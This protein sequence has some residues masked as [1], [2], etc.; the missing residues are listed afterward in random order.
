MVKTPDG[1]YLLGGHSSSP[2]SGD[3]SQG[4]Q[5]RNDFWLV[6]T[7][8][9]GNK[10]WDK[11]FGGTEEEYLNALIPTADGGYL[12]GGNSLSGVSGDKTQA[13]RGG[14]D[15]WVVKINANGTKQ[16]DKRFGGTGDD[17]LH[18]LIQLP[19]GDYILAGHSL[20][21]AGGDKTENSRGASDYWVVKINNS[22]TKIWDKRLGGSGEDWL[23]AAV[24]NTDGTLLL[25][26]RSTSG[27]SGDKTQLSRGGEDYWVIKINANGGKLWDKRFGG[28]QDDNLQ[29]L[30]RTSDGNYVLG[31]TSASDA[32]GD[33]TQDNR[34]ENDFWII[35]INSSG[36]KLW[37]KRYGGGLSEELH[38]L[39]QT[40]DGGYLLG[41]RSKSGI[42]GEKTQGTQGGYDYWIVKTYNT[43]N[44]SW[45]RR[46]GGNADEDLR[47]VLPTT[48]GGYVLAGRSA[49][50]ISGD[51]TQSSQERT[52]YWLVKMAPIPEEII[53]ATTANLTVTPAP[54]LTAESTTVTKAFRLETFP[55]PFTDKLTIRFTPLKT[56]SVTV[57]VYNSQ[58]VEVRM[59]W[60]GQVEAGKKVELNW[61]ITSEKAD[62]YI[63]RLI[64][65]TTPV[66]QKVILRK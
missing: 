29:A 28:S 55:N 58:G 1:G 45:D 43:G 61:P 52:D 23:E 34:G 19:S 59:L 4:S 32:T 46:F 64:S 21:G 35:K 20:S 25:G 10:K 24:L 41:G 47:T 39:S 31:G 49:S 5:G 38:S 48:E 3:K 16:W 11:R 65:A 50:G 60:N 62:L 14:K 37:D 26:G 40:S 8:G 6:K 15:Y 42:G 57:K 27:Q 30:T 51:K 22:G 9:T 13:S 36:S 66:Y 18:T 44:F 2:V 33:K 12:L 56:E 54:D 53:P 7:D 17:D 63:I